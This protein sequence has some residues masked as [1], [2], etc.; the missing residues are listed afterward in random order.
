PS[1]HTARR[2]VHLTLT[3]SPSSSPHTHPSL[4]HT[5]PRTINDLSRP[6]VSRRSLTPNPRTID[7]TLVRFGTLHRRCSVH[8][9]SVVSVSACPP[10]LS[11]VSVSQ[12]LV[13]FGTSIVAHSISQTLN[14][15]SSLRGSAPVAL[16]SPSLKSSRRRLPL[17]HSSHLRQPC[18]TFT[19]PCCGSA[20][21]LICGAHSLL[22]LVWQIIPLDFLQGGKF[23]VAADNYIRPPLTKGVP[24]LFSDLSSLYNHPGKRFEIHQENNEGSGGKSSN[25]NEGE[26][27]SFDMNEGA[28][29]ANPSSSSTASR[30]G[31]RGSGVRQYVRSKMLRL[32]WTPNL[33]LSFVHAIQRLGGQESNSTLKQ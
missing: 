12:I 30:E 2:H 17:P 18:S 25:D 14:R 33:H 27:N 13:G 5:Q 8:A 4:C 19:M 15:R 31:K 1:H 16:P 29:I 28:A 22:N 6:A 21:L 26:E 3:P 10:T 7:A 24:S 23:R 32:R 9:P 11:V 20:Q